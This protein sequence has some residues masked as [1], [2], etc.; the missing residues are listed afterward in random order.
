MGALL[1]SQTALTD[2]GAALLLF[3][4]WALFLVALERCSAGPVS[5]LPFSLPV[6]LPTHRT[7][8]CSGCVRQA[9]G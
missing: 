2:T 8:G 1:P 4:A 6:P 7:R 3:L 9:R 5:C